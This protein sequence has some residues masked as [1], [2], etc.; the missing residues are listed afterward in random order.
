MAG[1]INFSAP[2]D[3]GQ[4]IN[5]YENAEGGIAGTVILK[6]HKKTEDQNHC[7]VSVTMQAVSFLS[8]ICRQDAD[9]DHN[10]P[11]GDQYHNKNANKPRL[12]E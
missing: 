2:G 9:T 7:P 3:D 10:V 1:H 4:K 11:N 8:F 12:R 6:P 5:K